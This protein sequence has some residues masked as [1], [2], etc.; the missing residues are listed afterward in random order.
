MRKLG[1][2]TLDLEESIAQIDL[3]L[4]DLSSYLDEL[5]EDHELQLGETLGLFRTWFD[6]HYVDCEFK[7]LLYKFIVEYITNKWNDSLEEYEDGSSP[8]FYYG[9]KEGLK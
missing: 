8:V 1:D 2:I 6:I 3:E 5:W 4:C 7:G 9:P